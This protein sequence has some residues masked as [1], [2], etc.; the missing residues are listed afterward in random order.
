MAG[1]PGSWIQ[2]RLDKSSACFQ[3]RVLIR[4]IASHTPYDRRQD[5]ADLAMA[6]TLIEPDRRPAR[7][8]RGVSYTIGRR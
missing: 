3:E 8:R 5:P 1:F 6:V 7:E 2:C 4:A